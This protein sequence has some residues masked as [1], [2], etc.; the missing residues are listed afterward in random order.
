MKNSND[1][2]PK[3]IETKRAIPNQEYYISLYKFYKKKPV[4]WKT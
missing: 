3:K 1:I 4:K 2:N